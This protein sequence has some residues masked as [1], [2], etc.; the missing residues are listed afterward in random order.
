MAASPFDLTDKKIVVTGAARAGRQMT[1]FPA[2]ADL[3]PMT[4]RGAN[5]QTAAESAPRKQLRDDE[6]DARLEAV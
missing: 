1:G 4:S 6:S 5:E 2:G 3:L